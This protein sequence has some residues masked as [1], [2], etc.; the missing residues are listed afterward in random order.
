MTDTVSTF[1][2]Y[3]PVAVKRLRPNAVLPQYATE[4]AAC[5][6]LSACFYGKDD[7]AA[8]F[9][10]E[11]VRI[12][13]GL[14]FA[15][16]EGHVMLLFSR[17][18]H[19]ATYNITLANCV[20]VIDSDYRGEVQVALSRKHP[21]DPAR[22]GAHFEINTGDRIAQALILPVPAVAFLETDTLQETARGAS[23]FGSTGSGQLPD[24]YSANIANAL[25]ALAADEGPAVTE[26]NPRQD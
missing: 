21:E 3:L 8:L 14:A 10:G 18:G 1:K 17:S 15:V 12:P 24:A 11:S 6:D 9:A 4:G 5:F 22:V 16:P 13:T 25:A 23:G 7:Y 26:Q 20:G 2:T 19:G